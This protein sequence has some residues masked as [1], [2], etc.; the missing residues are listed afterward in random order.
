MTLWDR[1]VLL[2]L[3]LW[4]ATACGL[5]GMDLSPQKDID[6]QIDK[7]S[8]LFEEGHAEDARRA[9]ESLLVT[10][11][12]RSLSKQ[13]GYVLTGMSRIAAADGNYDEAIQFAKRSAD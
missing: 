10:L 9:Y 11:Q 4:T 5:A 13:L 7:A 1:M 6:Q 3:A 12:N 8:R 2:G